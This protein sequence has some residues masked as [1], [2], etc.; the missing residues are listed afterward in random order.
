MLI[1][2][3]IWQEWQIPIR[4][5]QLYD[6]S[7]W[8][9]SGSCTSTG[10][11][12]RPFPA[13]FCISTNNKVFDIDRVVAQNPRPTF[14][15]KLALFRRFSKTGGTWVLCFSSFKLGEFQF[16][17]NSRQINTCTV[18]RACNKTSVD[19]TFKILL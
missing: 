14:I 12:L 5:V 18:L 2:A 1:T 7:L 11:C 15:H 10:F 9:W 4:H 16:L 17:H 19:G 8:S 13:G 6:Q 3:R